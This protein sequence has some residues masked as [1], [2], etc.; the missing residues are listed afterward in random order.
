MGKYFVMSMRFNKRSASDFGL[1]PV[2]LNM[3]VNPEDNSV[4]KRATLYD[5][6]WGKENGFYKYPLLEFEDLFELVL[7]ATDREDVYGAA[8]IILEK[9]PEELL[10]QCELICSDCLRKKDFKKVVEVFEL[11]LPLNR[12]AVK[13]KAYSQMQCDYERWKRIAHLASKV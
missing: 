9:Y 13:N 1:V 12:C 5:F 10:H 6:G 7:C 4:W 2:D 11:R 8:A 3:A